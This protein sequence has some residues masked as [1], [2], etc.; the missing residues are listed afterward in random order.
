MSELVRQTEPR[1]R[2]GLVGDDLDDLFEGFFRPMRQMTWGEGKG[3]LPSVDVSEEE[4]K[5]VV[6]AD[7]P[8]VKKDNIDVSIN[9]GVLTI[10]AETK[11]EKQEKD[12]GSRVIRQERRMGKFVR[13]MRLGSQVDQN[14]VKANYEDG[15][16]ELVLPKLEEAKPKKIAI[17]VH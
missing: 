8:G 13:S 10:N 16:L 15:V 17:D 4:S 6:K 7:L 2:G 9:D 14:K 3:M 1:A 5:Y 12:E 11:E